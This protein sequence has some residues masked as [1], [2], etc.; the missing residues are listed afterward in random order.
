MSDKYKLSSNLK[1]TWIFNVVLFFI[2]I[3]FDREIAIAASVIIFVII[4][5]SIEILD[6]IHN[7]TNNQ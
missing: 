5:I 3:I 4:S 2:G 6:A 7:P 1:W